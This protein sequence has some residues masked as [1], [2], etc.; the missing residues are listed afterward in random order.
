MDH[1]QQWP[2]DSLPRHAFVPPKAMPFFPEETVSCF[3]PQ[4]KTSAGIE[5]KHRHAHVG[6]DSVPSQ[7]LQKSELCSGQNQSRDIS[8]KM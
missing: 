5:W 3:H 1:N 2:M 8:E 6:P 4:A 7:L